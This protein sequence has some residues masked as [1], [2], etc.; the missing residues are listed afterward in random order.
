MD[1]AKFNS[2]EKSL[3]GQTIIDMLAE[4]FEILQNFVVIR[5]RLPK[6]SYEAYMEL[7][8]AIREKRGVR[9]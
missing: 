1:H 4:D 7:E 6:K 3:T 9:C 8:V 2:L 5:A